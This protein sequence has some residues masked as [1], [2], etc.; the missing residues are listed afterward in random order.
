MPRY[1]WYVVAPMHFS[2]PDDSAGF[3]RLVDLVDEE[4]RV[5]V[6]DQLL[7]DRLQALLEVAAILGAGEERA[8]VERVHLALGEDLGHLVVDDALGEALGDGGLA[9]AGFAH[10]ERVVLAPA[11]EDL[12]DTLELRLAADERV[13]LAVDGELVQVL[14]EALERAAG[15]RLGRLGLALAFL[16]RARRL[17]RLGDAVRDVVHHVQARDALLVEEVDGV[18]IL[19]AVDGD[20]HVGAGHF[21][22]PGRLHVKDRALDDAL[23]SERGLRVDLAGAGDGRGVLHHEVRKGFLQLVDLR[24][25]GLQDFGRGRVVA[26]GEQQ[27]LHGDELV[28]LLAGLDEGHVQTD[29]QLLGNHVSSIAHCSGCWCSREYAVTCSTLLEAT[30]L[31]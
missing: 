10:Q 25:A 31:G 29:F 21:L 13:D 14:R 27:M 17:R 4:D 28:A 12:H 16:A 3:S 8:H 5:G 9:D 19:L 30:S 11:A 6:V 1:S 7:Q 15:L 18:G 20:Q 24:R 2:A 22:L 26:Q 23:E